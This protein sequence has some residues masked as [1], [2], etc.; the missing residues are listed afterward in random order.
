MSPELL[1]ISQTW[2]SLWHLEPCASRVSISGRLEDSR[3]PGRRR[4]V[5]CS[6]P[7]QPASWVIPALGASGSPRRVCS[8]GPS[9]HC[10][11]CQ[12]PVAPQ[13]C[14]SRLKSLEGTLSGQS[15]QDA[16]P[17]GFSPR[18]ARHPLCNRVGWPIPEASPF[19]SRCDSGPATC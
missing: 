10:P 1:E 5:F 18:G 17:W 16:H 12:S 14:R 2:M 19:Q 13:S 6:A 15:G 7:D 8:T 11:P 9:S 4:S 3:C